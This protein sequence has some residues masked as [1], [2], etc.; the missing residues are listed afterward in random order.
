MVQYSE[1]ARQ[2][3]KSPTVGIGCSGIGITV[4]VIT[5]HFICCPWRHFRYSSLSKNASTFNSFLFINFN[6]N[7]CHWPFS[8][9]KSHA[10]A[11]Q[12]A[13]GDKN[14]STQKVYMAMGSIRIGRNR[15]HKKFEEIHEALWDC[16]FDVHRGCVSEIKM[17]PMKKMKGK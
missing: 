2:L 1:N 17:R 13:C 15:T 11:S 8:N 3:A 9:W 5:L 6:C 4:S 14:H 12:S 7:F 16:R 10:R